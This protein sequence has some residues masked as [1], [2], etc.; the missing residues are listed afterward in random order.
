[1]R[2]QYFNIAVETTEDCVFLIQM[3]KKGKWK[4]ISKFNIKIS[5]DEINVVR[6]FTDGNEIVS[7]ISTD[8]E[9]ILCLCDLYKLKSIIEEIQKYSKK[10]YTHDYGEV[11]FNPWEM[12]V[13]VVGGDGGIFYSDKSQKVIADKVMEGGDIFEIGSD[14]DF[15]FIESIT[16]TFVEAEYFPNEGDDNDNY[17]LVAKGK[18][19]TE[20]LDF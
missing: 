2:K 18:D 7:L 13:W 5:E 20:F 17:I 4:R 19:F 10:I 16:E 3:Y 15:S 9:T 14:V 8:D 12:T 11:F 1:M 6:T